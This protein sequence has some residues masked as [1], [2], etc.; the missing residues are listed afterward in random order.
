MKSTRE[1][2]AFTLIELLVVIAIIAILAAILFPVFASAKEAAQ[3]TACLSNS[4]QMGMAIM[5]YLADYDS[6][7]PIHYA[8]NSVPPAG[9]PGHK[10]VE[11]ILDPYTR[12]GGRGLAVSL[13]A[14]FRC[15]LDAGGPYTSQDV[16]G[17]TSYWD[18]YGS[19][20]RFTKCMLSVVAGE[21]SS[22]NVLRDYTAIVNESAIEFPAESRVLRDEMFAV[23]DRGNTPDACDRY[24][25]DCDPPYNYY[26]RWH[27]TGGN[28]V[29]ADG[30]AAHVS[31]TARFD[32]S[33]VSPSGERSGDPHPSEGTWYWA[34][35]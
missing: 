7:M 11:V 28:M 18:A 10:G 27:S 2:S 15:P 19:S 22:N 20:Y 13:N 33:R 21:S 25:Y 26:R 3:R 16:P 9:Q 14:I 31:G 32:Q 1:R 5:Q 34:C 8:Y 17:S 29:F 12:G 24:G 23:F 4:R 6:T 35:D 30:H